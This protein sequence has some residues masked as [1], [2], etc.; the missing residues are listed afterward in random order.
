MFLYLIEQLR[1]IGGYL[2][3]V[4][5]QFFL[6]P[7]DVRVNT[8][9]RT[10]AVSIARLKEFRRVIGVALHGGQRVP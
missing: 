2:S 3:L 4:N 7:I 8:L 10:V 9:A 1:A 5:H 6:Q